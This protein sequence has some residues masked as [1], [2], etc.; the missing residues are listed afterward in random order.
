M[1][2]KAPLV[3]VVITTRNEEKNIENCL[4]SILNQSYPREKIQVIVV[5]NNSSDETVKLA[6][7]FTRDIF[8]KGNERST[9]RNF[10]AEKSKGKY[11]LYL[12][13]DMI[14]N[15]KVI[16]ECVRIMEK[17]STL[18]GLYIPEIVM[19]EGYWNKVRRF[20]RSFYDGTVVDCVRF[21]SLKDFLSVGGF[22]ENM[23]GPEDWDF[24]KQIRRLGKVR[25][26]NTPLYH[27]EKNFNLM[28]YLSKKS[29]YMQSFRQYVE[30]WGE[31][32]P[33][34]KKQLGLF[35]RLV[36]V[37]IEDGK[38]KK[39]VAQPFLGIGVLFL[40]IIV[41]LRYLLTKLS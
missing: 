13:A 37:F 24:D 11:Y 27:N 22:S 20:E 9:Q 39:F 38:W 32:D 4:S 31:D 29:Y 6:K 1:K 40:R 30:K 7:K 12:D 15:E 41:G 16:E 36:G 21:V 18:S 3:S 23:T 35:Y 8:Q 2:N 25:I 14:L 17:D 26:I 34:V 33:D 28:K 19:G 5:D 10:G